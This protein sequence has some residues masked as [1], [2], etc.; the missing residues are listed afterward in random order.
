M[1]ND[2]HFKCLIILSI[3]SKHSQKIKTIKMQN[4]FKMYYH[5][6]SEDSVKMQILIEKVWGPVSL[7][8]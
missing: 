8:F 2:M 6:L 4:K 7:H 3:I 5:E 1:V